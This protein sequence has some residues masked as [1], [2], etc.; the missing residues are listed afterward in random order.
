MYVATF[1]ELHTTLLG[2]ML[3]NVVFALLWETGLLILPVLWLLVRNSARSLGEERPGSHDTAVLHIKGTLL[4]IAVLV[5]C[6][7]PL[8]A[9]SPSDVRFQP[10]K[11]ADGTVPAEVRGDI[12]P[13]TYR[14]H[15]GA[16]TAPVRIPGWWVLLHNVSA[17]VTHALI[18]SLPA[19]SDLREARLLM[20][21]RN[22]ED[23]ALGAEYRDFFL[24]CYRPAKRNYE[25]LRREGLVPAADRDAALDWPGSPYLA[26][27]PGGYLPCAGYADPQRCVANAPMPLDIQ[28]S[29]ALAGRV[30]GNTCG[31]WW[32]SI[33]ARLLD[34]ARRDQGAF[35]RLTGHLKWGLGIQDTREQEDLLV[36]GMLENFEAGETIA[37]TTGGRGFLTLVG[38][39]VGSAGLAVGWG[40]AELVLNIMK[41]VMPILAAMM[42]MLVTVFIP[43]ALLFSGYRID[44]V[45]NL[46]FLVFSLVFVQGILAVVGWFDNYLI[47]SLY[48]NEGAWS[49]LGRGDSLFADANKKMLINFILATLYLVGPIIWLSVM[50][51]IGMAAA[52]A[53]QGLFGTTALTSAIQAGAQ[54]MQR[55]AIGGAAGAAGGGVRKGA[56][57]AQAAGRRYR[58]WKGG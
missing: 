54:G 14:D 43:F 3:Y 34:Y 58:L 6:M 49:F 18:H 40:M 13:T 27:M 22:I 48:E 2:W 7:M 8:Y 31:H 28:Q 4:A 44:A 20:A 45:I 37:G 29:A 57:A 26:A 1:L 51:S 10:P 41:Q 47:A 12:D 5:T 23:P 11:E 15:F 42:L 16:A 24:G 30:G 33:R 19:Y 55:A 36:R 25:V 38:D 17:G 35:D 32:E 21:S 53:A 50:A 46:S 52:R 9:L 56:G 39:A